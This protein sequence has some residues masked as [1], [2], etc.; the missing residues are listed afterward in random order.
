MNE[1]SFSPPN[2]DSVTVSHQDP[3]KTTTTDAAKLNAFLIGW[4]L[5]Y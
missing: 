3:K 5:S 1:S 4:K 2:H